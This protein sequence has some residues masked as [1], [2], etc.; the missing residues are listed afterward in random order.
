MVD[1]LEIKNFK[2]IKELKL[3]CKRINVFIGRPN[4]GKSNILE[5]LGLLSYAGF[6]RYHGHIRDFVRLERIGNLF[7]DERLGSAVEVNWD[8]N[9]TTLEFENGSFRLDSFGKDRQ[10]GAE[11]RGDHSSLN[12]QATTGKGPPQTFKYY[13]FKVASQFNRVE[14]EFLLPPSGENLMSLL[15]AQGE[16]RS[17]ANDFFSPVGLRLGLRPQENKIELIKQFEDIIVSYPYHLASE[18]LQRLVFHMAAIL[19]N[20]D[21]VL[22]FEEPEAHAFPFYTKYLAEEIALDEGGNQYFISTH[23]PYFLLP[24]LEKTPMSDLSVLLTYFE[25]YQTKVKPLSQD[26]FQQLTDV[27][28]FFNIDALLEG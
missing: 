20:R 28:V 11:F 5:T 16:L 4:V 18:T 27:D 7:Y 6:S 1:V 13:R 26:Q 19:T 24:L 25:D 23:N 15:L 17:T 22:V 8:R 3:E 2:S 14:A 12:L 9:P 21:S 10:W